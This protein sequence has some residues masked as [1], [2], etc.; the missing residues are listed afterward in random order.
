MPSPT[1]PPVESTLSRRTFIALTAS[2]AGVGAIASVP[3]VSAASARTVQRSVA[4]DVFD[5]EERSV[6][7]WQAA[8]A[9]GELTSRQ[10]V[11]RYL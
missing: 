8:L 4:R 11:E 3:G 10:L 2:A 1:P 7:E 9:R 6:A 5:V